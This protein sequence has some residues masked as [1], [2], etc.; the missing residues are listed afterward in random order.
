MGSVER[1]NELIGNDN[2]RFL[3]K[4]PMTMTLSG[5][6][7]KEALAEELVDARVDDIVKQ[8]GSDAGRA[9]FCDV[10][11]FISSNYIDWALKMATQP[12]IRC[13]AARFNKL[14]YRQLVKS[15]LYQE[16][17]AKRQYY[18]HAYSAA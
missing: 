7:R 13:P 2:G 6:I 1:I 18:H 8:L 10:A 11:R 3:K 15:R 17:K 14:C 12:G 16:Q 4:S 9:L 5:A